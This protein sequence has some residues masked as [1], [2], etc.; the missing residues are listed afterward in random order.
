MCKVNKSIIEETQ[1]E[2][3]EQHLAC[4][5]G[6]WHLASF[7]ATAKRKHDEDDESR[8]GSVNPEEVRH[9]DQMV[10]NPN[11]HCFQVFADSS[12]DGRRSITYKQTMAEKLICSELKKGLGFGGKMPSLE[13][14]AVFFIPGDSR[15][16]RE[17]SDGNY[18]HYCLLDWGDRQVTRRRFLLDRNTIRPEQRATQRTLDD[19]LD[20]NPEQA[21][22]FNQALA[23]ADRRRHTRN[24][25]N[26]NNN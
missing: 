15:E 7:C 24:R 2:E 26:N 18:F 3:G 19:Y 9:F 20:V 23:S 5:C 6:G 22:H 17:G 4:F 16:G 8:F 10:E 13:N 11:I 21:V 14:K 25:R 12:N 1:A